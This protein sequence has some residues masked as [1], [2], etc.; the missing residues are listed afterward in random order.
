MDKCIKKFKKKQLPK[1]TKNKY[2]SERSIV[3]S[4]FIS[5]YLVMC[6]L[7]EHAYKK[8]S[9]EIFHF[10]KSKLFLNHQHD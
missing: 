10:V 1:K 7:W 6:S 3:Y 4:A 5:S 8:V 2:C 9:T